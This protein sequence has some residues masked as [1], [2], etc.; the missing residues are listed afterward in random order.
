MIVNDVKR[1]RED[2]ITPLLEESEDL[3][4]AGVGNNRKGAKSNKGGSL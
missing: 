4:L 2:R 3:A 1:L